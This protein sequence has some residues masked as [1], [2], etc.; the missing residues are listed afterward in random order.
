MA[1]PGC[2]SRAAPCA[3]HHTASHTETRSELGRRTVRGKPISGG[4]REAEREVRRV[5]EDENAGKSVYS[6]KG[7][8]R[9]A[10]CRC[11][12]EFKVKVCE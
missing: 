2:L 4:W 10:A 3:L 8:R 5:A 7:C 9:N 12:C 1:C 6:G 11:G